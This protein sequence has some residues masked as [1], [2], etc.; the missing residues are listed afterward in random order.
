MP[1]H[2]TWFD[3]LL[4]TFFKN[5]ESGAAA[6]GKPMLGLEGHGTWYEGA[7]VSVQHLF[8]TA[9]VLVVVVAA[10]AMAGL[11]APATAGAGAGGVDLVPDARMSLRSFFELLVEATYGQMAAMMGR[12]AAKFFLPLIG[13]CAVLILASNFIGLIPGFIPPTDVLNTTVPYALVIF[14]A[15][16]I[17]GVREHGMAYFKH[18]LGPVIW[19]APLMLP[20]EI[21]SHI[22]RPASLSIRLAANMTA[23]H[24]ALSVFVGLVPFLV[25]VPIYM[26]GMLVVVVQTLV[27]CLLSTVY[28]SLAIAHDEH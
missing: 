9:F 25:P 8:G 16:H 27:F 18:F 24:K 3:Y 10:L 5:A 21:I 1:D 19:L 4:R 17:F 11:K 13:T 20:I 15:T 12:E 7:H 23:D 28:I 22:V 14:F 26:L 2:H 6:L